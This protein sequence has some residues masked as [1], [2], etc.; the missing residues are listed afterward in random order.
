MKRLWCL[1]FGFALLVQKESIAQE[2]PPKPNATS[3]K[4]LLFSSLPD[5]FSISKEELLKA[6]SFSVGQQ[7]K[8]QLSS[9]LVIEGT[10]VDKNQHTPGAV[11]INIR[12]ANYKN[13][14]FNAT[15]KFN[16]DNSTSIQGRILHPRYGDV[17]EIVKEQDK[18]F[19]KKRSQA[20]YMPE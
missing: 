15:I 11:S 17:L 12:V 20:L 2:I 7:L 10:L 19:V 1:V 18:Y 16:A 3:S 4:P 6:F 8:L 9:D 13:A 5:S 14:L